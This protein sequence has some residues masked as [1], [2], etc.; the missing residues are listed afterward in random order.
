MVQQVQGKM[1]LERLLPEMELPLSCACLPVNNIQLDSRR[2]QSGDAFFALDAW[3]PDSPSGHEYIDAAIYAGARVV[4]F[5][6]VRASVVETDSVVRIGVPDLANKLSAIAARFYGNPSESAALIAITGTNGKTTCGQLLAQ[7]FSLA[8]KNTGI[9][10]T[11]GA[12]V[13]HAKQAEP[14]LQ[15]TGF[16]TPDAITT[17]K[18]L[19]ELI[20]EG[21]D[22]VTM[23]VSSHALEQGRVTAVNFD[24]AL[25]TNLSRDHLDYHADMESYGAAK[26]RLFQFDSLAAAV[27]NID[28]DFGH[29][30]HQN[31]NHFSGQLLSYSVASPADISVSSIS[32]H[33]SGIR[34]QVS[35]PWGAGE[36]VTELVGSFNLSNLLAVLA[37]ACQQ[38]L[39]LSKVLALLPKL[40]A[41]AGRME[42]VVIS[43]QQ[44]ISVVVDFA[45]TPDALQNALQALRSD[46]GK[47]ICVFGC[48][49]DRD[50]GKRAEMGRVASESADQIVLTSDNPRS[51][52]PETIIADI[53]RGISVPVP[54]NLLADRAEAIAQSI[55]QA[56]AGDTVLI[57]GKGHEC[58]QIFAHHSEEF[59]DVDHAQAALLM[60]YANTAGVAQ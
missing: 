42:P 18:I 40:K 57:A 56:E 1:T 35:T 60:R 5:E 45:H 43:A 26:A 41:A 19:R 23:E 17:Q 15:K 54:V 16:T 20:L 49:G 52:T 9:V 34:A 29:A 4:V 14:Q 38:G 30:L 22:P 8:N 28:D 3:Q 53:A 55:A 37:V 58:E 59:S 6:T 36:L 39:Q 44:D 7:L 2:V 46:S 25:F 51:E 33:A 12:G 21:A 24:C 48:G 32:Y 31:L 10:G 27:I 13:W 47:L 11:L 50:S